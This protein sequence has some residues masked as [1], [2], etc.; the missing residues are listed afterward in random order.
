[1][2]SHKLS[3]A[4]VAVS[5]LAAGQAHA[6]NNELSGNTIE[7]IT[8]TTNTDSSGGGE[9]FFVID[10]ASSTTTISS[11]ETG[12]SLN[13]SNGNTL[14]VSNTGGVS[15]N[16]SNAG[17]VSVNGGA[18]GTSI[19]GAGGLSVSGGTANIN[20]TGTSNTNI[21]NT[22]GTTAVTGTTTISSASGFSSSTF[23]NAGVSITA[24]ND[25]TAGNGRGNLVVNQNAASMTV[26]NSA[27]QTH[28]LNVG[29]TNTVLSGGT[30]STTMTLDD[31]GATFA[32]TTTG[33]P[34]MVHGVADGVADFDAV[35]VR[36]L[37]GV[38][39][40]LE[41][42][43]SGIASVAAMANIPQVDQNKKF[44]V[45]LGYGNYEANS[46]VAVGAS[47]RITE[48]VVAKASYGTGANGDNTFGA[49]VGL[50]W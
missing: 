45:G 27:G 6:T 16:G 21:G 47:A 29:T 38:R 7:G 13:S 33:G 11:T 28:G 19:T 39:K 18:T 4:V 42:A 40:D 22:T 25:A 1:M 14:G 50:S 34:A 20:S 48:A 49:G 9:G 17:G 41:K 46:A 26:T 10:G 30:N 37:N 35:N 3:L 24:D 31:N 15:L 44:A 36:Q 8:I 2:V 23:N 5:L 43:E 12:T 32:N